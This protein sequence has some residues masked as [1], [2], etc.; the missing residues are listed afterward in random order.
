MEQ[1]HYKI[2][3]FLTKENI[4]KVHNYKKNQIEVYKTNLDKSSHLSNNSFQKISSS[5]AGLEKQQKSFNKASVNN[6]EYIIK[7]KKNLNNKKFLFKTL[8]SL[9]NKYKKYS[10]LS[11]ND[12]FFKYLAVKFFKDYGKIGLDHNLFYLNYSDIILQKPSKSLNSNP[13]IIS[14]YIILRQNNI[15]VTLMKNDTEVL[16]VF[17]S[18]L[19][20]IPRSD[21]KRSPSFFMV[22]K[23]TLYYLRPYI[24]SGNQ[25]YLFKLTFKGFKRFRRPLINRFLFNKGFQSKCIGIFNLDFEPFN[26]C[27]KRK[28]K[29]IKIKNKRKKKT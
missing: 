29:R 25:K 15:F 27:R 6:V 9:Y 2:I 11:N 14:V 19:F 10:F 26:G 8:F 20:D 16:K 22:I 3:K 1:N 24:Q 18:G 12:F 13:H 23:K 4:L 5:Q 21:R 7:K 17:S 28:S